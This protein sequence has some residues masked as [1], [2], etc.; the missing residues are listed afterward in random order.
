MSARYQ[1]FADLTVA[2]A[3]SQ[4]RGFLRLAAAMAIAGVCPG[5]WAHRTGGAVSP[6]R[7]PPPL[8]FRMHDGRSVNLHALLKGR[9]T[10]VQ[11]MF[12]GCT[13][14][15]PIQGALFAALERQVAM[16]PTLSDVRLLSASIDPFSDTPAALR[17]WLAKF[18]GGSRWSA[19]VP[20]P[21]SL[22]LWMDFLDGR[23]NGADRHTGQVYLFD[24]AGCLILR[25]V[26]FPP[27]EQILQMLKEAA[28]RR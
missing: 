7:Q 15:C 26:D 3:A 23:E 10:A 22:D 16:H 9:I 6:P 19:A 13:A 24:R 12:T 28:A 14:T 5:T 25:S 1:H 2:S 21:S 20:E 18:G 11:L 4:R 17:T 27:T 8:R